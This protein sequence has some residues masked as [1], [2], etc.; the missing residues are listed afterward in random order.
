MQEQKAIF[1]T[2]LN[3]SNGESSTF[4]AGQP[5]LHDLEQP[6]QLGI[7]TKP[8]FSKE[9]TCFNFNNNCLIK[10]KITWSLLYLPEIQE[11]V[12]TKILNYEEI[13]LS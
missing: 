2:L 9:N 1:E 8:R 11:Y 3:Q 7:I 10:M 6:E 4:D 5:R 13:N 12:S